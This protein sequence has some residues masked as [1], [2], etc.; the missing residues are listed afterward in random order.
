MDILGPYPANQNDADIMK[1]VIEDPNG[2]CKFSRTN[3]VFVI[4]RGFRDVV[5]DFK[6]KYF[7]V[8]I[9]ASKGKRKQLLTEQSSQSRFVTKIRWVVKAVHDMLKQKYRLLGHKIDNK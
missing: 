3:G 1:P 6:E 4:E 9:P 8:L 5:K 7:K 2:L